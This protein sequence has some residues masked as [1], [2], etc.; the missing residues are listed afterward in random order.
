MYSSLF[1]KFLICVPFCLAVAFAFNSCDSSCLMSAGH[2][3]ET[4]AVCDT[5]LVHDFEWHHA[6]GDS[7]CATILIECL[8]TQIDTVQITVVDTVFVETP[9][10]TIVVL[11]DFD[12][13]QD[14]M[15]ANPPGLGHWREC[16]SACLPAQ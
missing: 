8:T 14:C 4:E 6:H 2:A 13:V 11:P 16:L 5:T 3:H 1:I 10:D 7:V 15:E 9:P 12:C